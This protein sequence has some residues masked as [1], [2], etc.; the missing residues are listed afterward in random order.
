MAPT[1]ITAVCLDDRRRKFFVG[2]SAGHMACHNYQNGACMKKFPPFPNRARVVALCYV[3]GTRSVIAAAGSGTMRLYDETQLE[4]CQV[5]RQ[6]DE[7]YTHRAEVARPRGTLRRPVLDGRRPA[8]GERCVDETTLPRRA[9]RRQHHLGARRGDNAA[10][11]RAEEE[12]PPREMSLKAVPPIAALAQVAG[13]VHHEGANVAASV[14]Q[15]SVEGVRLWNAVDAKCDSVIKSLGYVVLALGFL[16]PYPLLWVCSSDGYVR[17]WGVLPNSKAAG[18]CLAAFENR[19]PAGSFYEFFEDP[20]EEGPPMLDLNGNPIKGEDEGPAEEVVKSPHSAR[21]I[22]L[23]PWG[24]R[25]EKRVHVEPEEE[26]GLP[27]GV[28]QEAVPVS[29]AA[30]DAFTGHLRRAG[31]DSSL[32]GGASSTRVEEA[33]FEQRYHTCH[34]GTSGTR[35]G[36]CGASIFRSFWLCCNSVCRTRTTASNRP[37]TRPST[38][39]RWDRRASGRCSP[40][41][42]STTRPTRPTTRC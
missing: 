4:S 14:S 20:D 10:S 22:L 34:A 16:E 26:T 28:H 8:L 24:H 12:T 25:K 42:S 27:I 38:R 32:F 3:H 9:S 29:A 31:R 15:A 18:V 2:T 41:I 36:I 40:R 5:L 6:F 17:I 37:R 33:T 1:D 7:G 21:P 23:P 11:G 39:V 30:F 35:S 19:P 13:L